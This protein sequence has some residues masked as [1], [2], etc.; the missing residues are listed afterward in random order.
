MR[1]HLYRERTLQ[2]GMDKLGANCMTKGYY[3]CSKNG[4]FTPPG[5][6]RG[7]PVEDTD[8]DLTDEQESTG[9]KTKGCGEGSWV[10]LLASYPKSYHSFSVTNT[11]SFLYTVAFGLTQ[12]IIAR[13]PY[14]PGDHVTHSWLRRCNESHSRAS[15][16]AMGSN[17]AFA[18]PSLPLALLAA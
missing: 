6:P 4:H 18:F 8:G 11:N 7:L 9:M 10:R 16:K 15:R 14:S 2:V 5:A 3:Q 12:N 17:L 13:I 1:W